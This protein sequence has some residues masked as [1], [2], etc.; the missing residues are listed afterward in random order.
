MDG[1]NNNR[2]QFK[3]FRED[4]KNYGI[5]LNNV[6]KIAK[7]KYGLSESLG[8]FDFD[9]TKD[10]LFKATMDAGANVSKEDVDKFIGHLYEKIEEVYTNYE[11]PA[12]YL[13]DKGKE[14]ADIA[15]DFVP[16]KVK[17]TYSKFSDPKHFQEISEQGSQNS[18]FPSAVNRNSFTYTTDDTKKNLESSNVQEKVEKQAFEK[19]ASE[20][21]SEKQPLEQKNQSQQQVNQSRINQNSRV[22]DMYLFSK[23]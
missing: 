8:S 14:V 19:Q 11:N 7:N 22:F 1:I 12:Q 15:E 21:Q 3:G 2:E 4:A 5:D 18:Y 23:F 17:E 6:L 16:D 13:I 20:K 9:K 10:A